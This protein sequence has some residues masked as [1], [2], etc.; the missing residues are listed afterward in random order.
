MKVGQLQPRQDL[1]PEPVPSPG[2]GSEGIGRR[3]A[4]EGRN[5]EVPVRCLVDEVLIDQDDAGLGGPEEGGSQEQAEHGPGP[6]A[7]LHVD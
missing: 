1:G 4:K 5:L 3:V 6:D 7:R 2:L